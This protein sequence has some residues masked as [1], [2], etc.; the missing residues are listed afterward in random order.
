MGEAAG[1]LWTQ[2]SWRK[3]VGVEAKQ[4]QV[5]PQESYG[6]R[7]RA[8]LHVAY[9]TGRLK[10][11]CQLKDSHLCLLATAGLCREQVCVFG[12]GGDPHME[13]NPT[14]MSRGIGSSSRVFQA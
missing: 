13:G 2:A 10:G 8:L 6:G 14:A 11:K 4:P 9:R 12:G 5:R 1:S 3:G 7:D